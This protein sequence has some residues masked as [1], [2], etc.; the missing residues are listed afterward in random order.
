MTFK[1]AKDTVIAALKGSKL[2]ALADTVG[3]VA[4]TREYTNRQFSVKPEETF[5]ASSEDWAA[6]LVLCVAYGVLDEFP[7]R[8]PAPADPSDGNAPFVLETT[9]LP[10]EYVHRR[11]IYDA[12]LIRDVVREASV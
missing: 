6:V 12:G 8:C 5:V 4:L 9:G 1:Q 3:R 7:D 2:S 10:S 11:I